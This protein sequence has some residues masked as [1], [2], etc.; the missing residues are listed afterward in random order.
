ML[1]TMTSWSY[2]LPAPEP[3]I[4][5]WLGIVNFGQ[6]KRMITTKRHEPD[7]L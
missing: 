6:V 1:T 4:T 3:T 2:D 5:Y 7:L